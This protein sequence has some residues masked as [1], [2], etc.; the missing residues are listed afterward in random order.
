MN[1]LASIRRLVGEQSQPSMMR[2]AKRLIKRWD[3]TSLLEGIEGT[4]KANMAI[5][6]DTQAKQLI[7]EATQTSTTA[8]SEEWS[9]V[10]L[11]LV[12]KV[13]GEIAAKNFVSVQPLSLPSGLV[14]YVDFQFGNTKLPFAAN[15]SVY[16]TLTGAGSPSDGLYGAG[17]W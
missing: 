8:G 17:R 13:F 1:N 3:R 5:L 4:E 14:F 2:K 6:L 7:K 11:P 16:G 9:G 15:G 12:R 10:A